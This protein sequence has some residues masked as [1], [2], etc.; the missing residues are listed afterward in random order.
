MLQKIKDIITDAVTGTMGI[1]IVAVIINM[2]NYD[3]TVFEAIE[4]LAEEA[5]QMVMIA[6][7]I[8]TGFLVRTVVSAIR[9]HRVSEKAEVKHLE[10]A[11]F[12]TVDD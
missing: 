6:G 5:D 3:Y 4:E 1:A 2:V 8:A 10:H 7:M 11:T 9:T 12:L